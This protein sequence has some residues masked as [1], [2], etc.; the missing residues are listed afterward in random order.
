MAVR[1]ERYKC[2][3]HVVCARHLDITCAHD[4]SGGEAGAVSRARRGE[5]AAVATSGRGEVSAIGTS[6]R[7][8]AAAVGTSRRG[9]AAAVGT[10]SRGDKPR[11]VR[12]VEEE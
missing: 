6:C 3:L 10:A 7:G 12:Q 4:T 8:E 1:Y 9:E 5:A 11:L 2:S